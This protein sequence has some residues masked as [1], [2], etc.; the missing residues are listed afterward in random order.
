MCKWWQ[1]SRMG[2][3]LSDS[4]WP[5]CSRL[6][7]YGD[8]K[9]LNVTALQ[10][11]CTRRP[12]SQRYV[13]N[14]TMVKFRI[15]CGH[16]TELLVQLCRDIMA[17]LDRVDTHRDSLRGADLAIRNQL[18]TGLGHLDGHIIQVTR[19]FNKVRDVAM[20]A[21]FGE[22]LF[23]RL[24]WASHAEEGQEYPF[25]PTHVRPTPSMLTSGERHEAKSPFLCR[26]GASSRTRSHHN[27]SLAWNSHQSIAASAHKTVFMNLNRQTPLSNC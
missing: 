19:L 6:A 26:R 12:R 17:E 1:T 13:P 25:I 14:A 21:F 27:A 24:G 4:S 2:L 18:E 7:S 22:E 9:I 10:I 20:K 11:N 3:W 15:S 5:S 16:F 23:A 8:V